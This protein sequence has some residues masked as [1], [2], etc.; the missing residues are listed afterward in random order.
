MRYFR[1]RSFGFV[2]IL[3]SAVSFSLW[4]RTNAADDLAIE[5]V[6]ARTAERVAKT[7][8]HHV[9]VLTVEGCLLDPNICGALDQKVRSELLAKIPAVQLFGRSDVLPLLAKHGL[10]QIDGYTGAVEPAV[11]DLGAEVM[12]RESLKWLDDGYEMGVK[13]EDL[14]KRRDLDDFKAKVT[15]PSSDTSTEPL[16]FREPADGP[17]VLIPRDQRDPLHTHWFPSCEKCPEPGYTDEA[18]TKKIEGIVVLLTTITEQGNGEHISVIRGLGAGLTDAAVEAV[19]GWRFKPAVGS[20]GKPFATRVPI[21][22]KF[23]LVP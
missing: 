4:S 8:A 1:K 12:V 7:H 18:R 21:E 6:A 9:L 15:R 10:L 19:R 13:V 16:I 17:A 14:A 2:A 23:R 11:P 5:K 20:D 3:V 22:V